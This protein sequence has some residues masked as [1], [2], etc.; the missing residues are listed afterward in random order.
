MMNSMIRNGELLNQE[1]TLQLYKYGYCVI[2]DF[3]SNEVCNHLFQ[4]INELYE[5]NELT[6]EFS[7]TEDELIDNRPFH[8]RIVGI[9][10]TSDNSENDENTIPSDTTQFVKETSQYI[11]SQVNESF[12]QLQTE[13]LLPWLP[14]SVINKSRP[15][16]LHADYTYTKLACCTSEGAFL[17]KHMDNHGSDDRKLTCI[18]YLNPVWNT[19]INGGELRIHLFNHIFGVKS[20]T[21]QDQQKYIDIQPKINRLV[22]FW[23]DTMV[24][25]VLPVHF[26]QDVTKRCTLT[27]WLS[28]KNRYIHIH[29][30][31]FLIN[32]IMQT[33]WPHSNNDNE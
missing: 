9:S 31:R 17:P 32:K 23:S 14:Y 6:K 24:H 28:V 8:T 2:D 3:T 30:D 10:S 22:L 26:T 20:D 27:I 29:H 7:S 4:Q 18:L 12:K 1:Q 5:K 33:A 21:E 15:L 16:D 13:K 25:E 11:S 19:E